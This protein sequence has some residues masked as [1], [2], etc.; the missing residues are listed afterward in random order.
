MEWRDQGILLAVRRHGE[1]AAIADVFTPGRGRH[2]GVVRGATSRK[3]AP[4]L[5]PGAQLDISWKARLEEHLGH[6]T[7]EPVRSRAAQILGDRL[8][9]AGLNAVTALLCFA[10]PEREAHEA[11]Y[12]R[13]ETLLDLLGQMDLWPL[14]YLHWELA[15]LE[16]L[17]YG[18]D[19]TECAVTGAREG[20]DYISPRTGRA[21]TAAGAGDWA[22]RLL[23]LPPCLLRQGEAPDEEILSGFRVT[24]HFLAEH[25]APELGQKP[26][27]E[28][29]QRFVDRFAAGI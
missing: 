14:A 4:V 2:A 15:L 12:R 13:T 23:P 21:V 16:D 7:V 25:L 27:P 17:G 19:L 6:F 22:D 9:L 1:S 10:L 3:L 20:L 8:A 29:R 24:G 11:L 18:L 26:I 5:Q 28:A